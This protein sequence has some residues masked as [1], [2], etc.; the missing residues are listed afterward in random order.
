M[1]ATLATRRSTAEKLDANVDPNALV[2]E[3]YANPFRTYPLVRDYESYKKLFKECGVDCYIMN[4]GFFL[5][6]KIPK[7]VTLDLLERLVEGDLQFE[8]FG[9]YE[10]LSYVEVPGF[11]PPFDVREYHHQLHQAFEFRSEYV[12]KL[13]DGKMNYH[14]KYLMSKNFN[15]TLYITEIAPLEKT[16]YCAKAEPKL[17]S[18]GAISFRIYLH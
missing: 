8:P 14:T 11:E 16:R 18:R 5:E 17:F 10:N 7:E 6:K 2:I 9:A 1:G 15:V 3:P 12:E 13:K 4:T